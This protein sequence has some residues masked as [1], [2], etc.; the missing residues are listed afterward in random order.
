MKKAFEQEQRADEAAIRRRGR[1]VRNAASRRSV[2]AQ[3]PMQMRASSARR[4]RALPTF[5]NAHN[6]PRYPTQPPIRK[7]I[8]PQM[9]FQCIIGDIRKGLD[10]LKLFTAHHNNGV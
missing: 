4:R 5:V 7:L 1:S 8:A 6:R 3:F 9:H 2:R 10:Q